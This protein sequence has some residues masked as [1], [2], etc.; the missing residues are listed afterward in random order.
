[1]V[2][3][4]GV[5]SFIQAAAVCA[6]ALSA[7]PSIQAKGATTPAPTSSQVTC[8]ISDGD[9]R[10][11]IQAIN[12]SSCANGGLGCYNKHCRYC[13]VLDTPQSSHLDT[14]LSHG[15]AFTTTS[16]VTVSRGP[17]E[18]SS[19]DVAAGIAAVTDSGCLYGGLGCFNDHCRFCKV[20][21]TPQSAG[22][23]ACSS[24][25]KSYSPVATPAPVTAAPTI[26][27]TSPPTIPPTATPTV[28]ATAAPTVQVTTTSPLMAP[29]TDVPV[30]EAPA[31]PTTEAPVTETPTVPP[32]DAPG[33]AAPVTET[34]TVP[35]T[36]APGTAAPSSESPT[37]PPSDAP[38]T[39]APV[40]ET[41]T[42][43]PTDTPGTAVPSSETPTTVAP[44]SQSTCS[45]VPSAGDL[46]A[47]VTIVTDLSCA[48]GGLGC[49]SDVCRFC[50]LKTTPQSD[51][52]MDCAL[53]NGTPTTTEIPATT[54]APSVTSAVA[55]TEAPATTTTGGFDTE[56]PMSTTAAPG[57]TEAPV[58]ST[59]APVATTEVPVS[60]T[61][62]PVSTEEPAAT[63]APVATVETPVA[64]TATPV[65][66]AAPD[67]TT[68]APVSADAPV[69][70][71]DA[72]VSTET[73]ALATTCS[74]VAS[75]E[76]A[77]LGISVGTDPSCSSGGVGCIDEICRFCKVTTSLQSA[78]Y[79]DCALLE[80]GSS[81]SEAPALDDTIPPSEAPTETPD[82]TDPPTATPETPETPDAPTEAPVTVTDAPNATTE[83]PA[84]VTDTDAPDATTE[85][86]TATE[87]PTEPPIVPT[88]APASTTAA[89]PDQQTCG[90]VAAAG[91]I[92]VGVHIATDL[93]CST[94]GVG[95]INDLCRFC[96]LKST[97]QSEAFV[98]CS[99]L[100]GF[101]SDSAAPVDT[102]TAPPVNVP[103]TCDLV[104]S[105]GDALVGIS[106][107]TDSA[108]AVGGVGCINDVCR[109]CKVITSVQSA[110]FIDCATV[111][112]Y[113]PATE[114]PAAT[115][116]PDA[117]TTSPI[118]DSTCTRVASGGDIAVGVDIFTDTTCR[119][120]G[121][122]CIDDVCRFC[123]LTATPQSAAFVNCTSLSG[124][125]PRVKAPVDNS[126]TAAAPATAS[127]DAPVAQPACGLVVSAGDAA[128]GIS[129]T[130]DATC[131]SGVVGCI[132]NVCRFCKVTTTVQSAAFVD[133]TSIA[134][135]TLATDAPIDTTAPPTVSATAAPVA[136]TPGGTCSLVVSEGDAAV[137]IDIFADTSCQFGGVGCID[138]VCRFC[139]VKT[140]DQS[141]TFVDCPVVITAT[142]PAATTPPS[143]SITLEPI[144]TDVDTTPADSSVSTETPVTIDFPST[145]TPVDVATD[146]PAS[147][148]E[149]P[150][151][152]TTTPA[153]ETPSSVNSD[154]SDTLTIAPS[155]TTEATTDAPTATPT[156]S[157][158]GNNYASTD[159]PVVDTAPPAVVDTS[160]T[161]TEAP[162]VTTEPPTKAPLPT[163]DDIDDDWEGSD[164]AY[165]DSD[166]TYYDS[167]ESDGGS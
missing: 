126:I 124:Y 34:P 94:G 139:K 120:G 130:G 103:S 43:P 158:S 88:D 135:F 155:V 49:L 19:G 42:V 142:P 24:L 138:S 64:T 62:A 50:K 63:D 7:L 32:T 26:P 157:G 122:G 37:V 150:S 33:T 134:G 18:V 6:L 99:S 163:V 46:D 162:V 51:S 98:D 27:P 112:G 60:T 35:P 69:A 76:D 20:V 152:D 39:A 132:D 81:K 79:I 102:T 23:M 87:T 30:T 12:D 95:C 148:T 52:Y 165:S 109:F 1:M 145:E 22:F 127:T 67:A 54:E 9:K 154:V 123:Q 80:S 161:L 160:D 77:G 78:P 61:E 125:T 92:V 104:A 151:A 96:K 29:A 40:T 149:L 11:G 8:G 164:S 31:V 97:P 73:P 82:A 146:A 57:D 110:A 136:S 89:L 144:T 128:V 2:Y 75:A 65:E 114:T 153:T 36:D 41:P 108:C 116:I 10:V 58:A 85:A 143:L 111:D 90:I 167:G 4:G 44:S 17:C 70:T 48:S 5:R 55:E 156:D 119:A 21:E 16:T 74:L 107:V 118:S 14:C 101:A 45:I 25:D 113:T 47:G 53:V 56:A 59:D 115:T 141:A 3:S 68:E 71:S 28:P 15:V 93:T 38:G 131:A 106:I 105:S 72:P 100:N 133:C 137:G 83:V 117:T 84:T 147:P 13:K 166:S 66:T 91:D 140:T 129:I 86:P 159:A 121:V